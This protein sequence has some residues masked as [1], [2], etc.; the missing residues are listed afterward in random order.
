SAIFR[1]RSPL[2]SENATKRGGSRPM[3]FNPGR[4]AQLLAVV[5]ALALA[6]VPGARPDSIPQLLTLGPL[7]VLNGTAIVSGTV[8]G[9]GAGSQV[10]VKGQLAALA[11][12]GTDVMR[13][14]GADQTFSVQV[15]GTTKEIT[16]TATDKSGVS[17]TTRYKV[18]DASAQLAT[19]LG[20]SVA[21]TSA[22]G[23]KIVK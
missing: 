8:G 9:A 3:S 15:P 4:K 22:V 19:P 10:T 14:L 18:L 2:S 17:E 23:L 16:L 7:T 1:S 6:L 5:G 21:A 11:V 20:T 12:N 13:L